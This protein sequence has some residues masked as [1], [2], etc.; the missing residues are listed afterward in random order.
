MIVCLTKFL[1]ER[2]IFCDQSEQGARLQLETSGNEYDE[3][4]LPLVSQLSE[5]RGFL[6]FYRD[7]RLSGAA[8]PVADER[9]ITPQSEYGL[10]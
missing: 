4:L 10:V 9:F 1:N 8:D 3:P 2:S 5:N 7:L 6:L